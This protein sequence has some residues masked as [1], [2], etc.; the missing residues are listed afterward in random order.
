MAYTLSTVEARGEYRTSVTGSSLEH[1]I[2]SRTADRSD[3]EFCPRCALVVNVGQ[4][5]THL[6]ACS[7][8]T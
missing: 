5:N 1:V 7:G 8:V 2:A 4:L 3:Y 6:A